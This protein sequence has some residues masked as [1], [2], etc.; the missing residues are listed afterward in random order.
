MGRVK[1]KRTYPSIFNAPYG[2]RISAYLIDIVIVFVI[3]L[4]A[5]ISIDG[6]Y[7]H[8]AA[9]KKANE[10]LFTLRKDSGLFFLDYDTK[11]TT[12]LHFDINEPNNETIYLSRLEHF[13]TFENSGFIYE[14]SAYYKE[15]V[16][17]DYYR[18]V[19]KMGDESSLFTFSDDGAGNILYRYRESLSNSER[20]AAWR[21]VYQV[22][23]LD[24]QKNPTYVKA[25]KVL[26]DFVVIN[27]ALSSFIGTI[28][29]WLLIPLFVGH[30]RS[31][32]KF[33]TGLAVV[34]KEGYQVSKGQVVIRFL[35]F[36]IVETA[37]N[38]HLFFIPLFLT[39]GILT[40]THNNRAFH[41]LVSKTYV[42]NARTS[43]IFKNKDDEE[44]FFTSDE[45]AQKENKT[46]FTEARLPSSLPLR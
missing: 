19:L 26:K 7:S 4:L 31:V 23:L 10:D 27:L 41:D 14:R 8:S 18:M 24:L 12:Y 32:G 25:E 35:V 17:F 16:P 39:S 3:G 44:A 36:A 13:Y 40:I 34:N 30:G 38:F 2:K 29:P 9:G 43:R 15:D 22:A 42:V 46:F 45:E 1:P 37:L 20:D 5:F 33:M 28:V 6:I 21:G 11:Q